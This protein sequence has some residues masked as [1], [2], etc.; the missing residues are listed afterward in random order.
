M[1]FVFDVCVQ[2]AGI[3][4]V[5]RDLLLTQLA[6]R[7]VDVLRLSVCVCLESKIAPNRRLSILLL[8]KTSSHFPDR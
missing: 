7:L 5:G 4:E 6:L 2:I 3:S 1:V 8:H